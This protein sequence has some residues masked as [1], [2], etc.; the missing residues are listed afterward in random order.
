[1][2]GEHV[3]DA[4]AMSNL[5]AQD[6]PHLEFIVGLRSATHIEPHVAKP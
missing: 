3:V 5:A 2:G 6:L 1:M 4:G